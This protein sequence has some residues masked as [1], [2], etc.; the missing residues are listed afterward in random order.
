MNE[1]NALDESIKAYDASQA[2]SESREK[3]EQWRAKC[4]EKIDQLFEKKFLELDQYLKLRVE[5]QTQNL[6]QLQEKL[7]HLVGERAATPNPADLSSLILTVD[8]LK[9]DMLRIQQTYMQIRCCPLILEDS[10]LVISETTRPTIDLTALPVVL[11]TLEHSNKSFC[12]FASNDQVLLMHQ[13]TDLCLVNEEMKVIHKTMWPFDNLVDLC[14]SATLEQ[15]VFINDHH[16][17][18]VNDKLTRVEKIPTRQNCAW[19]SCTCSDTSLFVSTD[20]QTSSIYVFQLLPM[21]KFIKRWPYPSSNSVREQIDSMAHNNE[22]LGLVVRNLEGKTLQF[23]LR[24][25]STFDCL[26]SLP[27]DTVWSKKIPFRC[28]SLSFDEWLISDYQNDALIHISKSGQV[29]AAV[30]YAV[31]PYHAHLFRQH[32]LVI[33]TKTGKNFHRFG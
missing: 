1:I 20:E 19:L 31:T 24:F 7:P 22:T 9:R 18:L 26:W 2:T 14:W 15:F 21:I 28:C 27:L 6:Q 32:I 12:I 25:A 3:L 5:Q 13:G 16:L 8:Q 4:H 11:K 17:F 29:K 10:M 33:L 30:K 23:E